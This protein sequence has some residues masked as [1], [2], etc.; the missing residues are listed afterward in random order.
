MKVCWLLKN[1]TNN[2]LHERS[3]RYLNYFQINMEDMC[4][5]L[6]TS[7]EEIKAKGYQLQGCFTKMGKSVPAQHADFFIKTIDQILEVGNKLEKYGE[8]L[9]LDIKRNEKAER[10]SRKKI[11][12]LKKENLQLKKKLEEY[13]TEELDDSLLYSQEAEKEK[14]PDKEQKKLAIEDENVEQMQKRQK[15]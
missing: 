13:E 5:C 3:F 2:F 15:L 14:T 6:K 12:E 10:D 9:S 7:S 1:S 4:K 8:N 11:I